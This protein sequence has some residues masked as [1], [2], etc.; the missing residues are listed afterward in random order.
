MTRTQ[1][2][3]GSCTGTPFIQFCLVAALSV[4]CMVCAVSLVISSVLNHQPMREMVSDFFSAQ[5][6][7]TQD[8]ACRQWDMCY[9]IAIEGLTSQLRPEVYWTHLAVSNCSP[10]SLTTLIF[11][12]IFPFF[13]L[14]QTSSWLQ[15]KIGLDLLVNVVFG[16]FL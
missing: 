6:F 10:T 2:V 11:R 1:R 15:P 16:Q 3:F 13:L 12:E 9:F 14:F 7:K 8:G 5:R 4:T